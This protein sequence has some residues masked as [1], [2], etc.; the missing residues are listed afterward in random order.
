MDSSA[1]TNSRKRILDL[2]IPKTIALD[3]VGE[4]LAPKQTQVERY[5]PTKPTA[6]QNQS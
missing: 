6:Q 1:S 4:I 2:P 3:L 5:V